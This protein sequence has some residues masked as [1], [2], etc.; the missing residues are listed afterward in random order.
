MLFMGL[1]GLK[2]FGEMVLLIPGTAMFNQKGL[3]KYIVFASILQLPVVVSAVVLG[4][5]GRFRWKEQDF[6][7]KVEKKELYIL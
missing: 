3:R 1:F 4:V 5:F 6:K 2:I 7:R